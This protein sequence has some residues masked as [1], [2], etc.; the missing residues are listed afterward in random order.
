MTPL[1]DMAEGPAPIISVEEIETIFGV[2][3][4][5]FSFQEIFYCAV[6]TRSVVGGSNACV[7]RVSI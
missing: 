4:K 6:T 1:L 2:V 3:G 5:I 7:C